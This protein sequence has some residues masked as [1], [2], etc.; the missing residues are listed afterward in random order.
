MGTIYYKVCTFHLFKIY[1]YHYKII[2]LTAL[3]SNDDGWGNFEHTT[4]S[5]YFRVIAWKLPEKQ[6]CSKEVFS[7][8][9]T[10]PLPCDYQFDTVIVNAQVYN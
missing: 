6:L 4:K 7:Y 10:I 8:Q 3:F 9:K 2:L 1:I 5:G